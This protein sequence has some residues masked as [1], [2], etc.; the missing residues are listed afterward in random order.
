MNTQKNQNGFTLIELIVVVAIMAIIGAALVPQFSTMALRSRM[1]TDVSTIKTAQNQIEIYY[2]DLGVW[3]GGNTTNANDVVASLVA[4]SYLDN[5]YLS[6][7]GGNSGL[8][9]QTDGATVSYN[10]TD[11]KLALKVTDHDYGVYNKEADKSQS[12]IVSN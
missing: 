10:S 7:S 5:R 6:V 2:Q 1:S 11:H 12:W 3:P 8:L 9:I 4:G